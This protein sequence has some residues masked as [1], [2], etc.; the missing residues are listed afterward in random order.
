MDSHIQN[1]V[2]SLRRELVESKESEQKLQNKNQR[3]TLMLV[4]ICKEGIKQ[5]KNGIKYVDERRDMS[6]DEAITYHQKKQRLWETR[7]KSLFLP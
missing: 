4:E 6:K 5:A 3:L 7:Q 1:T 2:D